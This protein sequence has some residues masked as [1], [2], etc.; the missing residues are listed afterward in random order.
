L[1]ITAQGGA[2]GPAIAKL[3]HLPSAIALTGAMQWQLTA[4]SPRHPPD[5]PAHTTYRIE[6][7]TKGLAISMPAPL[8]KTA[9][10]ERPLRIEIDAAT[11]DAMLL[12]GSLGDVRA[13]ARLRKDD[14]GWSFD[15]G[16]VRADAVVAAL[17]AHAGLRIEG[18]IDRF[19]LDDWLKLK[20]DEPGK[21]QLS[22]YLRAASVRVNDFSFLGY[23]WA[24]VRV[25]LQANDASWRADVA[26]DDVAGQVTI[27]YQLEPTKPLQLALTKLNLGER[28]NVANTVKAN[29]DPRDVP[30]ISGR[31][32]ELRLAGRLVGIA[33]FV[34]DKVPRGVKLSSGELRGDSFTATGSGSWLANS[35]GGSTSSLVLDVASTDVRDTLRA[36][37][38][39]DVIT[40]K[41]ANGHASL[42]WPNGVDEDLLGRASGKVQIE[43][44][45]GQLLGVDPGGAGRVLGL[46]SIGALPRRL[47]LDFSDVTDKGISFDSVRADFEWKDGD[48]YTNNLFLSGPQ[49]E[50]GIVGRTGFAKHD[51]DLTAVGTG[52]IGGSLSVAG[53]V[54]GG[55]VLGAAVLAF[56][57]LFKEPL[58]GVTRRYYHVTGPWENPVVDRIDK[59]EAKQESAHADAAVTESKKEKSE[60]LPVEPPTPEK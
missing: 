27:P 43:I 50:V 29:G 16:G 23:D 58:K 2:Q 21:H 24:N 35:D 28:K 54:V 42:S 20:S 33:R 8:G 46:L 48:A 52:D 22:E 19:V 30:A 59:Q 55:P 57:R 5:E 34:L 38:F 45:D 9:E 47:A 4:R 13:I 32:D 51:Y 3:A 25:I 7:D 26:G 10:V 36:F 53:A 14:N 17:P 12:R 1:I 56:S 6:S 39:R 60:A 40:G 49:A 44:F 37:N 41:R 11:D 18:T 31:V 15:R